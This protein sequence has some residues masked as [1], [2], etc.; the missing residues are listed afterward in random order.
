[1]RWRE[2][3]ISRKRPSPFDKDPKRL[4]SDKKITGRTLA[5]LEEVSIRLNTLISILEE[6]G[7]IN[8]KEYESTVAMRLHE[9]SKATAFEELNEEL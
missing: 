6:R 3:F 1:M 8:R 9:V 4:R 7:I 2:D 5:E